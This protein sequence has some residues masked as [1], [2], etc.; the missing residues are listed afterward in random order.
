MRFIVDRDASSCHTVTG[1]RAPFKTENERHGKSERVHRTGLL[2]RCKTVSDRSAARETR[3]GIVKMPDDLHNY[4]NGIVLPDVGSGG[5]KTT[6][7]CSARVLAA[8]PNEKPYT[9]TV[10]NGEGGGFITAGTKCESEIKKKTLIRL[11]D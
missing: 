11:I 7:T 2:D 1:A 3:F 8:K 5:S 10:Q 4:V 9:Q 6:T